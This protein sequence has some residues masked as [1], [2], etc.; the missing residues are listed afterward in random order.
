MEADATLD[1]FGLLC[2]MPIIKTAQ[3]MKELKVGEVLEVLATDPGIREDMPAWCRATRNEY[4]GLEER[5]GEYRV[6]VRKL[7]EQH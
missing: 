3:K 2:P 7:Q 4:L 6:Y 1:T 5:E